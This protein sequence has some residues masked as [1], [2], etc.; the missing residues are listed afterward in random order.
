M[1]IGFIIPE[2]NWEPITPNIDVQEW[3]E[4]EDED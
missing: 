1:S 2:P 4:D 3:I